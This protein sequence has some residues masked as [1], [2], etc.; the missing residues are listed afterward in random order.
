MTSYANWAEGLILAGLSAYLLFG[1]ADFGA[2]LWHLLA[3]GKDQQEIIEH[4]M[5][6]VWEANHVWLIFVLVMGW[7]AFPPVFAQIMTGH[8]VPLS[9]GVLGIV[10][11]GSAFV[12]F[13]AIPQQRS[14]AWAFGVS[15][16]L[17]PF[18]LG[19]V[20]G[21]VATGASGWLSVAGC[22]AGVLTV[23]LCAYLASV[24]LTWDAQRTGHPATAERFRSYALV[25]GVVTGLLGVPG[26]AVLQVRSPLFGLSALAGVV[27]LAL[28]WRRA[29]VAVRV[30]AGI[31]VGAVL[32]GAAA[33]SDLPLKQSVAADAVLQVVFLAL[34]V[35]AVVLLPSLAL[36]YAL[37]QR[38][39]QA[40][41]EESHRSHPSAW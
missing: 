12:F 5:G 15:S 16:V 31:A 29:Y 33:M 35:G 10:I 41:L 20:A 40:T 17:T 3:K 18:C 11:R 21:A 2:G 27:S 8:W 22:Y 13:K 25:T 30:S 26:A 32:W 4:A 6:P 19:S 39:S 28:L 9:L 34:G 38:E 14:F 37:F 36:L 7:T 1:G 24:Y 23:A